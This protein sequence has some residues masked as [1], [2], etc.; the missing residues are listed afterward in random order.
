MAIDLEEIN[1]ILNDFCNHDLIQFSDIPD[2]YLY[3]D[4]VTTFLMINLTIIR[5]KKKIKYLQKR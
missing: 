3:M 2:I 4:Q 5:G 1:N